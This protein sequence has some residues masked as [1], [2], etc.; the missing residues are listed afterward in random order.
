MESDVKGL[1]EPE[2]LGRISILHLLLF[3][4]VSVFA[5]SSEWSGHR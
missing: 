1:V 4:L 3:N 2:Q 5:G